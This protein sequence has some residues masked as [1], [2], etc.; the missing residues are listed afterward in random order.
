[1]PSTLLI[2]K[3]LLTQLLLLLLVGHTADG[4]SWP[5]DRQ[6]LEVFF[7]GIF[8]SMVWSF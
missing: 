4:W 2:G 7:A 6:Y 3:C 5:T 8:T 1:M